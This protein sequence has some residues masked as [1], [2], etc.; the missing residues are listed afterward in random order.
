M[1][2]GKPNK[3]N[4][5]DIIEIKITTRNR[6]SS[7]TFNYFRL[8]I[9]PP[10]LLSPPIPACGS[11]ICANLMIKCKRLVGW[12][13]LLLCLIITTDQRKEVPLSLIMSTADSVLEA[14]MD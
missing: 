4:N 9:S 13:G 10:Q 7:F 1:R 2:L 11:A 6:I 12:G 14:E 8:S 5:D 3:C